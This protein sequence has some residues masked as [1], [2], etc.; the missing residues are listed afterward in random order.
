VHFVHGGASL[1]EMVIPLIESNRKREEV[2]S[3]VS[4]RLLNEELKVLS[5]SLR[6]NILQT[7]SVT[8][9]KKALDIVA[10]LYSSTNELISNEL[11]LR[12]GSTEKQAPKRMQSAILTLNTKGGRSDL[13]TLKIFNAD[14]KDRLNPLISEN[15][16]NKTLIDSDF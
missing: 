7:E 10:G 15:V 13:I 1:Q 14:D 4:L 16:I 2:V 8:E 11:K 12:L 5:G 9:K 3:K 6:I